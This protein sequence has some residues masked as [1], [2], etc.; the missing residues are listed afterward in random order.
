[1][2][3]PNRPGAAGRGTLDTAARP[4]RRTRRGCYP[5]RGERSRS[6]RPACGPHQRP[7]ASGGQ[8]YSRGA[9]PRSKW[10]HMTPGQTATLLVSCRDRTGLV[11]ALSDFVFRYN[12]NILDA[13][14]HA[15]A[16]SGHFFMRL[17]WDLSRFELDQA[18]MRKGLEVLA[19]RFELTWELTVDDRPQRVVVF[20]SKTPHCLYDLLLNQQ[21]GE[22]GGEIV[23]VVS[24]HDTLAD[25]CQHF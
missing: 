18:T 3:P 20:V 10:P 24:N 19:K 17:K 16:E 21:L 6:T 14:Q 23:R 25:V 15:E 22:L 5:A 8:R 13:D 12:G 11:A 1:M 4:R 2:P 9:P 7:G